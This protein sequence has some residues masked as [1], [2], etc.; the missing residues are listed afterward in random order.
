MFLLP[1]QQRQLLVGVGAEDSGGHTPSHAKQRA[2]HCAPS[3]GTCE[4]ARLAGPPSPRRAGERVCTC[5][6]AGVTG[7]L[8]PGEAAEG[9]GGWAGE[10]WR[11]RMTEREGVTNSAQVHPLSLRLCLFTSSPGTEN[12]PRGATGLIFRRESFLPERPATPQL[13]LHG[14]Q[15]AAVPPG[16]QTEAGGG[17]NPSPEAGKDLVEVGRS[18]KGR[19]FS[20]SV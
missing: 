18:Q 8:A 13:I 10:G 3:R 20:W 4:E 17:A 6:S 12:K 14:C 1:L 5:V 16:W 19:H 2:R 15:L 7:S 9:G 11:V